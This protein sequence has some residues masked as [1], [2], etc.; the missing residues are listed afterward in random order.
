[1]TE[2][3]LAYWQDVM[4]EELLAYWQDVMTEELLA[5]E[6]NNTW[7]LVPAPTDASV[8]GSKWIYSIKVHSDG[9]LDRYKARLVAQGYKQECGIDYEETFAPVA[10]MTTI[11]T[12]LCVVAACNWLLWQMNVKNAF[13][14]E[15]CVRRFI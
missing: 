8:I 2:E 15:T 12:L 6:A 1:M 5:L 13:F 14:M 7:E 9:S 4:T 3:L 11:C 10:K